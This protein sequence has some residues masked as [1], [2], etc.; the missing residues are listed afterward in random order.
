MRKNIDISITVAVTAIS[1]EIK[2]R[3]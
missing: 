3:D 2:Y 1:I